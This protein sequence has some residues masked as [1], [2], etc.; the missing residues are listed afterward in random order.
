MKHEMTPREFSKACDGLIR[1]I[2]PRAEIWTSILRGSKGSLQ[3]SVY[4][5][6]PHGDPAFR[7][8]A[9]SF[10]DLFPQIEAKWV[11]Y[12]ETHRAKT[13]RRLALEIIR[14]TAELGECTDAALRGV[15]GFSDADVTEL[16]SQA[17]E[18]A[19]VIAGNGPFKIV[20]NGGA[21]ASGLENVD[22]DK[23]EPLQ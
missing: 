2:G 16:G 8:E 1:M 11:A 6:W 21:N 19:N 7:I 20:A 17:C 13:I 23:T 5:N 4:T 9:D 15:Y 14:I 12:K 22:R 10:A 18:D 3:S